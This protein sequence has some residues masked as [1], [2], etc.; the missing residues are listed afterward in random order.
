MGYEADFQ[1]F[2]EHLDKGNE[3]RFHLSEMKCRAGLWCL[4]QPTNSQLGKILELGEGERDDKCQRV[5]LTVLTPL[6]PVVVLILTQQSS[7]LVGKGL[8]A[9]AVRIGRRGTV[10]A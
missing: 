5:G 6:L 3:M 2:P 9:S 7:W 1:K 4:E 8:Y 10:M